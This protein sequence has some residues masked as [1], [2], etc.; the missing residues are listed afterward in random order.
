MLKTNTSLELDFAAVAVH[1]G[2]I[3][4]HS[5]GTPGFAWISIALQDSSLKAEKSSNLSFDIGI[6]EAKY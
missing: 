1:G 4:L 5:K 3:C 6:T 2:R